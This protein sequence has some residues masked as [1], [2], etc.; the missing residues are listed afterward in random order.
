MKIKVALIVQG[1]VSAIFGLG[2]LFMPAQ[3]MGPFHAGREVTEL[4]HFLTR[5]YG[6][7]VLSVVAMCWIGLKVTEKYAKR[8]LAIGIGAWGLLTAVLFI[9]GIAAGIISTAGW[10]IVGIEFVLAGLFI[11]SLFRTEP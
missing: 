5:G 10:M 1:I 2:F 8:M 11:S 4:F 3:A 9:Y 6:I 7:I